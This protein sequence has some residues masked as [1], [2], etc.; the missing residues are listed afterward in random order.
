MCPSSQQSSP[1]YLMCVIRLS[2]VPGSDFGW[3]T[4]NPE[5]SWR[6]SAPPVKCRA[7]TLP[8]ATI[9]SS[10]IPSNLSNT[11]IKS[12]DNIKSQSVTTP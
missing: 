11:I 1:L 4:D 5:F 3:N 2:E 7:T 10:H 12:F 8:Q 9:G 6:S